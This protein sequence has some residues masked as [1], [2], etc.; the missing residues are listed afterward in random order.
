[1]TDKSILKKI[2]DKV[3]SNA[4]IL[5]RIKVV[6]ALFLE[7]LDNI[8]STLHQIISILNKL[9]AE[10]DKISQSQ[11][12]ILSLTDDILENQPFFFQ[13]TGDT[14]KGVRVLLDSLQASRSESNQQYS[15]I[16]QMIK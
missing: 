5:E 15:E 9:S 6:K 4:P 8:I 3:V 7:K 13:S 10:Q 14:V 12:K 1:M 16:E 2:K 11:T